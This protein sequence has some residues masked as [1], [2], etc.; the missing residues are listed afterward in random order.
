TDVPMGVVPAGTGNDLARYLGLPRADPA[1]AAA[2]VC[3]GRVRTMDLARAGGSY[4]AT[5]LASGFDARVN[6]RANTLPWARGQLRYTIATAVELPKFEP[7]RY[8]LEL[9]E[10]RRQ[11]DAMMVAVGNGPSYGGGLRIC[12][13]AKL[14]D[15]YLDLVLFKPLS[16]VELVTLFPRLYNGTHVSHP[17]YEHHRVSRVSVAAAGVT[18]YADGERVGMLPLTVEAAPMALTVFVPSRGAR[19]LEP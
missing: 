18:A 14:D 19:S 11:V 3:D 12:E 4:Y 5:V 7:I 2:V 8:C 9:D 10:V 6:A 17:Q 1:A 13:G 16:R 15:G